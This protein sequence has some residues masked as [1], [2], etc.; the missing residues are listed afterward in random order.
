M[1]FADVASIAAAILVALGGGGAIVLLLSNWLGRVWADRLMQRE[2]ARHDSELERLRA[3]LRQRSDAELERLR[4]NLGKTVHVHRLQFETE[5]TAY[6]DIWKELV[7]AKAMVLAL[8][9]MLDS[10]DPAEN[11]QQRMQ[12]RL[13]EFGSRYNAFAK[14]IEQYRP[15]YAQVVWDELFKLSVSMRH[16]AIDYQYKERDHSKYWREAKA[17]SEK[18][19]NEIDLVCEAI[20]GRLASLAVI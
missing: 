14:A 19:V 16:E 17:N 20:R 6:R 12:R 10:Y 4:T 15:F 1:S 8:R 13:A 2:R 7:E 18:I 3:D 11:E 5:F 9:R